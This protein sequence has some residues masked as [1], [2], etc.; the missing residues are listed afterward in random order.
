MTRPIIGITMGDPDSVGG[1][2]DP[3]LANPNL[4]GVSLIDAGLGEKVTALF[5]RLIAG[6]GA[7]R[8]TLK[9]ELG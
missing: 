5:R 9:A 2:L 4:F 8:E 3:I 6:P 7:V 1:T